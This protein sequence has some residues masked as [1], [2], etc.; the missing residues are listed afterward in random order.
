[1]NSAPK[2]LFLKVILICGML[3]LAGCVSQPLDREE[4]WD[5]RV[6]GK[7]AV[8]DA[9][10][11]HSARFDWRQVGRIYD[12][13]VW[14][15]LGQGRTRLVGDATRMTVT[16]GAEVLANGHPDDVMMAHLGWVVPVDALPAWLR[17]DP[18][19]E[20]ALASV[21]E[22]AHG[23]MTSFHQAGWTVDFERYKVF[24]AEEKPGRITAVR[25]DYRVRVV[26]GDYQ[27]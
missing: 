6:L 3:I 13:E 2:S 8:K 27:E 11:G 4:S 12:V 18:Y 15:P 19:P 10:T 25:G 9:Q 21:V 16:R 14:G 23:R 5:F 22:D 20:L 17:G 7:L 1:M 24:G 26:I